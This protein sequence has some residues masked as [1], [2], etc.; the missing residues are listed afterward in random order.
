MVDPVL[1]VEYE[2][3]EGDFEAVVSARSGASDGN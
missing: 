2:V 1:A 3:D